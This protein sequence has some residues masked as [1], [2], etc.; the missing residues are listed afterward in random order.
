MACREQV[1]AAVVDV[2]G[3]VVATGTN[4]VPKAGGGV[5]GESFEQTSHDARCAFF[6]EQDERYCRNT[7]SQNEI[8]DELLET[9]KK[10]LSDVKEVR[11][12]TEERTRQLAPCNCE[13]LA[14]GGLLEFSRAVHAEMDALL[15]AARKGVSLVGT[16][17]FVTTFP[18][19]YCARHI[20]A[21][22]VDEV[23]YIE[24]YP[25]SQALN[26]HRDAIDVEQSNWEPPSRVVLQNNK[27]AKAPKVL[28]RPFSGIAPRLYK[29]AF[30]K[31]RDLKDQDT[32]MMSIQAP[33]WGTPWH[34]AKNSPAGIGSRTVEGG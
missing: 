14:S 9:F 1:G 30:M 24:P 19:H 34:L 28:F 12:L 15:S 11:E 23:Q 22:A 17:L 18:C 6:K 25:K 32:G 8:I 13:R 31:D 10:L 4:E 5:Y 2:N 20:I 33:D 29:R 27:E 26:L 7:R 21:A 3:N 16:R